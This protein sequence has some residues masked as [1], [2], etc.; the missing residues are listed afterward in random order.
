[1]NKKKK[2]NYVRGPG[3]GLALK[4]ASVDLK[5]GAR[6]WVGTKKRQRRLKKGGPV[7]GWRKKAT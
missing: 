6:W 1:M 5:K 3:G 7:V 2:R 4:K